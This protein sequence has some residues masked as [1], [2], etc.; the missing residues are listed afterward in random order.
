MP[1]RLGCRTYLAGPGRQELRRGI[2]IHSKA[3]TSEDGGADSQQKAYDEVLGCGE[4]VLKETGAP[5]QLD[6]G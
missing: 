2:A 1:R 5:W 3:S 4:E 6:I